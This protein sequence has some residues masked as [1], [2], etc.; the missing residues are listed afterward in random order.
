M[1]KIEPCISYNEIL[2]FLTHS[3]SHTHTHADILLISSR[4]LVYDK[5]LN[6]QHKETNQTLDFPQGCKYGVPS[7]NR[8]H[9]LVLI[10]QHNKFS[11]YYMFRF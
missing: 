2:L 1:R 8:S 10:N 3:Y 7:E 4:L 6:T 5:A 9:C 11:K